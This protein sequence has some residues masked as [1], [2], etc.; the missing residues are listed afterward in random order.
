M[1]NNSKNFMTFTIYFSAVI[2]KPDGASWLIK[3][4]LIDTMA[5]V[6]VAYILDKSGYSKQE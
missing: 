1:H 6:Y 5:F 3:I 4:A 2:S